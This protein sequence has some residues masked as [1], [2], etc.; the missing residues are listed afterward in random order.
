MPLTFNERTN[1]V[2]TIENKLM[3]EE[4]DNLAEFTDKKYLK[5]QEKKTN[6]MKFNFSK[7][8]DFRPELMI[9]GFKD[10]LEVITETKLLGIMLSDDLK[11]ASN[12]DY[13]CKRGYSK[14][15]TLRR[16]KV[17]D[18]EP[19][20]ILDVYLKEIRSLLE[21]AVPAWHSGRTQRQ[22]SDIERVQKVALYTGMSEYSY[23]M[24][25]VILD[26]EPLDVRRE[27]L[28][29]SFAKKTLKSRHK[30]MFVENTIEHFTREKPRFIEPKSNTRRF[31]NSPLNHMTRLLNY[32]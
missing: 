5:I 19:T 13:I 14:M 21:L 27:T 30:D 7:N 10:N 9:G 29:L 24:A 15:W 1:Q 12:T 23:D 6:V 31:I 18:V 28:C 11:W 2:L 4:L 22:S 8:H 20:V 32:S 25:L 17:L 16:M 26:L 3:Q